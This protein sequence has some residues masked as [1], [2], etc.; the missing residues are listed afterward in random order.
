[1]NP[2]NDNAAPSAL[3][4]AVFIDGAH[5]AR[6]LRASYP[7]AWVGY[8]RLAAYVAGRGQLLRAYFY[9]A[10]PYL[11][12]SATYAE[13]EHYERR[14]RFFR[15]LGALPGFQV[16]EGRCVQGEHGMMQ[17]RVDVLL[18]SDLVRL[19]TKRAIDVAVVLTGDSDFVP[20]VEIAK[21]EGVRVRLVC[22]PD[23]HRTH[24]DLVAAVDERMVIDQAMIESVRAERA[25]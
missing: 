2:T 8:D 3:R 16:R 15:V 24:Q 19:A 13:R 23:P 21:D 17:K 1:M 18:A 5:L 4:T 25:A 9:D 7:D 10:L 12:R 11:G 6:I 22:S 14:K 20:A